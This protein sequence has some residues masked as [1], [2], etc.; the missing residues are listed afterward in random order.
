MPLLE[1]RA[2]TVRF[3]GAVALHDVTLTARDNA[4]TAVLGRNGAGKTTLLRCVAGVVK[5]ATGAVMLD[6]HRLPRGA[7]AVARRGIRLVPES[8]NV[9]TDMTVRENLRTGAYWLRSRQFRGRLAGLTDSFPILAPL[10]GSKGGQLSGG[11]RQFVAVARVLM[12]SPRLVLLDEPSLGLSPK[13][14][15]ELLTAVARRVRED[16]VTVIIAEQNAQLALRFCE[17]AHVLETGRLSASGSATAVTEAITTGT[18]LLD[19]T[20]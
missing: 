1:T 8:A 12:A 9:F 18:G 13:L 7:S 5:P 2:L 15:H 11:E 3:G 16:D 14:A 17:H 20:L 4:V 6:D 19:G 10:L